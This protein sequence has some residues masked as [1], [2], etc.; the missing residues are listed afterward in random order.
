[1]PPMMAAGISGLVAADGRFGDVD[2]DGRPEM[3]L[4]RIPALT[5]AE[6]R[7]YLR[8]VEAREA[9]GELG[10][11]VV[12]AD[13][14][15]HG[16]SF[17]ADADQLASAAGGGATIKLGAGATIDQAR[18][19]VQSALSGASGLVAYVGHGGLDRLANEGILTSADVAGLPPTDRTAV[20]ASLTC[21]IG[22]FAIPG[23]SSLG[24][25]LVMAPGS[26]AAAVIAPS[27]LSVN[28]DAVRLGGAIV[29]RL[30]AGGGRLGDAWLAG[31][32]AFAATSDAR[33]L[34]TYVVFGDPAL[35]LG[36]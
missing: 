24:E 13:D 36:N 11:L 21:N 34:R 19:Q 35:R 31:I 4:G 32:E 12:V 33:L 29:P 10:G 17:A 15:D 18:Q 30:A 2:D 25:E 7:E 20:F 26:G 1:M 3:A 9:Q 5:V 27:W 28:A 23:F 8:K 14:G 6:V 16:G 22:Y